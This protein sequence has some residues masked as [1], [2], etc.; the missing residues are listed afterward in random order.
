[1]ADKRDYYEVLGVSKT[2]SQDEIKK[3]YRSLAK[4]YHPDLNPNDK[5]AE[6]KFKE[7]NEAYETLSDESKRQQY[8]QFGFAGNQ[9]GFGGFNGGFGGASGFGGFEDIFSSFFGGGRSSGRNSNR[10]RQGD[11]IEQSIV[12]DF[13]ESIDGCKKTIKLS[14]DDECSA[15]GGSGAYSKKDIHVCERCHGSGSVVVEQNSL[16]G[17]V[18]TQTTCPKS[19]GRGQEIIKKCEKCNGKGRIRKVKD[20]TLNIPAGIADGMSMRLEGKGAAGFNGGPNG[21]LYVTIKVR[22]SKDFRREG[23]DIYLEV[24][25]SFYQAALGDNIDVPTPYGS[26]NLKIPAGTQT[27]T[28]FRLRGKGVKNVRGGGMGDQFVIVN[29]VTPTNLSNEEKKLFEQLANV[30]TSKGETPWE[31]FKKKFMGK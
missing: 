7:V 25:I 11:D 17:R 9:Q 22:P 16:F 24:P 13:Q 3:A 31:K 21:D 26:V 4:K 19:G 20:I 18:Q 5:T 1:M 30:E 14:V 8:D 15:C 23:D 28:K 12:I 2:A 27:G 29:V 6:E 10:P